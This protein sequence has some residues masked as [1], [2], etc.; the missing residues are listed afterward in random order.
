MSVVRRSTGPDGVERRLAPRLE[1][2]DLG[3]PVLIIGSRLV[4]LSPGGLMLEAPI[5]IALES[6]LRLHLVV[7]GERADVEGRVRACVPRARGRG[8]AWGVGLQF[9]NLA[10]PTRARLERLLAPPRPGR[11]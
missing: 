2:A 9:E 7:G 10:P 11:A 6:T 4:N 1:A 8:A 5:P 3:E